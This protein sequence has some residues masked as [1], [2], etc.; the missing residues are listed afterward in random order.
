[1]VATL[2]FLRCP[3]VFFQVTAGSWFFDHISCHDESVSSRPSPASTL[4]MASRWANM[5]NW[6]AKIGSNWSKKCIVLQL[7]K[8]KLCARFS[9]KKIWGG[10][11][12]DAFWSNILPGASLSWTLSFI[13]PEVSLSLCLQT[14]SLYV[15]GKKMVSHFTFKKNRTVC[16]F[17]NKV[18][19]Q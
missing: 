9:W 15:S 2:V 8:K 19:Q 13:Q 10:L 5:R 17:E 11:S 7:I 6:I 14:S 16:V 4:G 1:M 3:G 12:V 18:R